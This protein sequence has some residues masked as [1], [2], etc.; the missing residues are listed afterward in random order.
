MVTESMYSNFVNKIAILFTEWKFPKKTILLK[1]IPTF[2]QS[3]RVALQSKGWLLPK[4]NSR[5]EET[6]IT[7]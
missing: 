4:A 5:I 7:T 3:G 2:Y 1:Q 6:I